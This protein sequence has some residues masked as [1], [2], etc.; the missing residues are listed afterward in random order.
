MLFEVACM[1]VVV[2]CALIG[3]DVC[4]LLVVCFFCCLLFVL[5]VVFSCLLLGC[6]LVVVC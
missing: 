3:V 4:G 1:L 5:L 6:W 2:C